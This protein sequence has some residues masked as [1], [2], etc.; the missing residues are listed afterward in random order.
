MACGAGRSLC[1]YVCAHFVKTLLEMYAGK[2]DAP[3]ILLCANKTDLTASIVSAEDL[4]DVSA[5]PH[6]RLGCVAER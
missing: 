6:A 4:N 2:K 1:R 5:S 3:K